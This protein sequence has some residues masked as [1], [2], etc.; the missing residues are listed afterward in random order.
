[1]VQG[2]GGRA[3]GGT[4]VKEGG[5]RESSRWYRSG[6]G[7]A[8]GGTGWGG[9]APGGTGCGW[10]SSRWYRGEG[11]KRGNRAPRKSLLAGYYVF[12]YYRPLEILLVSA[13]RGFMALEVLF[14]PISFLK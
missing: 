5:R 12:N 2:W 11:M 1:V 14:C 3:P 4:E 8:P 13:V 7:R 9:R 10:E 6:E